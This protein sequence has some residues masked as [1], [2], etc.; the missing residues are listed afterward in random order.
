MDANNAGHKQTVDEKEC[1]QKEK[2]ESIGERKE[3]GGTSCLEFA[4]F[5]S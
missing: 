2:E 4:T 1:N 3:T 5:S